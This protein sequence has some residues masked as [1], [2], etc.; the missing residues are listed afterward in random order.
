MKQLIDYYNQIIEKYSNDEYK[1]VS[2][3]DKPIPNDWE[4]H[5]EAQ[6]FMM[7]EHMEDWNDDRRFN[8][9]DYIITFFLV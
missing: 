5:L 2:F 7:F 4:H 9:F 6:H 8:I 1:V 3:N